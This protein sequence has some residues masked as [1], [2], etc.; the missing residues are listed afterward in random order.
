MCSRTLNLKNPALYRC[1]VKKRW[2]FTLL[3]NFQDP[4]HQGPWAEDMHKA[5]WLSRPAAALQEHFGA[6]W[7]NESFNTGRFDGCFQVSHVLF[8][9]PFTYSEALMK[10]QLSRN[11]GR[12]QMPACSDPPLPR[13]YSAP[14]L[15]QVLFILPLTES[16]QQPRNPSYRWKVSPDCPKSHS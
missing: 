5:C 7:Q 4:D 8:I 2:A 10:A 3:H 9:F 11:R 1:I 15:C 12:A 13:I 16:L 6:L 14:M